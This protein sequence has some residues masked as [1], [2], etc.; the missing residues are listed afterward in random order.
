MAREAYPRKRTP[1]L[2]VDGKFLC[3]VTVMPK[4]LGDE[5]DLDVARFLDDL[6]DVDGPVAEGRLCLVA[7]GAVLRP[8]FLLLAD[9][10]HAAAATARRGVPA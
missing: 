2:E 9:H 7:R 5:L 3:E 8:A 10:A 1:V 4:F 6:L